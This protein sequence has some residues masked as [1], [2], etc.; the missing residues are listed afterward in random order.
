MNLLK[1]ERLLKCQKEKEREKT[2]QKEEH[3]EGKKIP[4]VH[5]PKARTES[6]VNKPQAEQKQGDNTERLRVREADPERDRDQERRGPL[7]AL[8]L[9]PQGVVRVRGA[10]CG[11]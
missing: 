9:K 5:V 2:R 4:P 3:A 6:C 8:R 11:I 1:S 10:G 7:L